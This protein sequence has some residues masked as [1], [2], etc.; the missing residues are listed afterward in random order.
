MFEQRCH[1]FDLQPGPDICFCYYFCPWAAKSCSKS[2]LSHAKESW[3][4]TFRVLMYYTTLLYGEYRITYWESLPFRRHKAVET[5]TS[6]TELSSYGEPWVVEHEQALWLVGAWS[7][8]WM[9]KLF[10]IDHF[11]ECHGRY[12]KTWHGEKCET[13]WDCHFVGFQQDGTTG[14]EVPINDESISW[15][16]QPQWCMPNGAA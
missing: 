14:F 1:Y 2:S 6:I 7:W 5:G 16:L 11:G 15:C 12:K 9:T 3:L 10:D 13:M 4:D 8:M